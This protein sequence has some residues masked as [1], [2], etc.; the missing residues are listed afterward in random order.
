MRLHKATLSIVLLFILSSN[1]RC[2]GTETNKSPTKKKLDATFSIWLEGDE[3]RFGIKYATKHN[4]P[5]IYDDYITHQYCL[6]FYDGER[7]VGSY[8]CW[9]ESGSGLPA[10]EDCLIRDIKIQPGW[11]VVFTSRHFDSNW[12]DETKTKEEFT[13]WYRMTY[14]KFN[15]IIPEGNDGSK[16]T[17]QSSPGMPDLETYLRQSGFEIH[18]IF[19]FQAEAMVERREAKKN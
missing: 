16:Y 15:S 17:L 13:H 10:A 19:T 18:T 7:F 2:W 9:Y 3:P 4:V 12:H 5:N 6:D 8:Y 1:T 14:W 11:R